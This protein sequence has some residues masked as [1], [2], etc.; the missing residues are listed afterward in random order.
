MK[1]RTSMGD[2]LVAVGIAVAVGV[3]LGLAVGFAAR[4]LGWPTDFVGPMTGA[5][6][7]GLVVAVYQLRT[8]GSNRKP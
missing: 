3:G 5:V 2:L 1:S 7:G 8:K 4:Q 6:V